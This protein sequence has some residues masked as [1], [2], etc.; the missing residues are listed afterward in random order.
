MYTYCITYNLLYTIL[1]TLL[2]VSLYVF[3]LRVRLVTLNK[4]LYCMNILI[5]IIKI[6]IEAIYS[7][8]TCDHLINDIINIF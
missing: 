8:M 7:L 4:I 3:E 1:L 6:L 2:E 5:I